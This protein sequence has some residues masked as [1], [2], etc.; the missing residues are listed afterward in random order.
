MLTAAIEC[1]AL[2]IVAN[3]A[4][5]PRCR[6]KPHKEVFFAM[7][8]RPRRAQCGRLA[9]SERP[10]VMCHVVDGVQTH[11]TLAFIEHCVENN[12]FLRPPHTTAWCFQREDTV[13]FPYVSFQLLTN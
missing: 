8:A 11:V 13:V 5:A 6:A 1:D 4:F 2:R 12:T 10:D 7:S 3:C 9:A